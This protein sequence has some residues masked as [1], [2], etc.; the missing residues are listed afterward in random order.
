MQINLKGNL[1]GNIKPESWGKQLR[2]VLACREMKY[3]YTGMYK[4]IHK[5]TPTP[6]GNWML[7]LSE[8]TLQT[9]AALS[10]VCIQ[11]QTLQMIPLLK[12]FASWGP[13]REKT[14]PTLRKAY[15]ESPSLYLGHVSLPVENTWFWLW[16]RSFL[17]CKIRAIEKPA[18][19]YNFR[20][21]MIFN[22][23][24]SQFQTMK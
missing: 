7:C 1:P 9:T 20:Q 22:R 14:L 2:E 13:L 10:Q 6:T 5:H 21:K 19:L 24:H 23:K 4:Y 18:R 8:I 3:S 16:V 15:R 11:S 17:R 12:G